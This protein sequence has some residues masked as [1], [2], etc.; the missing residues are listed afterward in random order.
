MR[1][2]TTNLWAGI[3]GLA[4][5]AW[6]GLPAPAK[7]EIVH[8]DCA[9]SVADVSEGSAA[10]NDGK[11]IKC[12]DKMTLSTASVRFGKDFP[13]SSFSARVTLTRHPTPGSGFDLLLFDRK[14]VRLGILSFGSIPDSCKSEEMTRA[15]EVANSTIQV[16]DLP[17][18]TKAEF[19]LR[20]GDG[21]WRPCK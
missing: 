20:T 8:L 11:P 16:E 21:E 10:W 7:A 15:G 14:G 19:K 1:S 3:L 5:A 2:G 9:T 6:L 4:S 17:R 12:G 13:K 18:V